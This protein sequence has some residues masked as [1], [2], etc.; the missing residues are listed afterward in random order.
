LLFATTVFLA[1]ALLFIVEPMFARMTLPRL[2]GAPAVWNTAMVFYQAVLLAGYGA[3]HLMATRLAPQRQ[4]LLPVVLMASAVLLL[5]PGIAAGWTPPVEQNPIPWLL[6]VMTATVGLPFL[7]LSTLSPLLQRWFATCGAKNP[8][9]LY[10]ASNAGSLIGLLA[11]PLVI[12]PWLGLQQQSWWWS[13]G[14]VTV[15]A[16][17]A[18][19]AAAVW[20][21]RGASAKRHE[22]APAALDTSAAATTSQRLRWV[23]LALAPSSLMLGV[24]SHLTTEV[25][26]MPLLW[27]V[28]LA[29]YL[30][31]FI[32]VFAQ[33]QWIKPSWMTAALPWVVLPLTVL[34]GMR[35]G[36]KLALS[37]GWNL[38]ALFVGAMV[39]HGRLAA[40]RP[41]AGRLT[42]F[43]WRLSVGGMLGGVFNALLAPVLFRWVMEYP[44]SVALVCLLAS[45]IERPRWTDAAGPVALGAGGWLLGEWVRSWPAELAQQAALFKLAAPAAGALLLRKRPLAFGLAVGAL[46]AAATWLPGERGRVLAVERSFFGVHRVRTSLGDAFHRLEHGTTTHGIQSFEPEQRGEPL[47][48]YSRIGPVGQLFAA[49]RR[50]ERPMPKVG[51]VGLGAGAVAAYARPG[52]EWTFFEIDPVVERIARDPRLFTHLADSRGTVKVTLGDARLSLQQTTEQFDV[53]LLDAYSSD[54]IPLHL[55]TRE[56]IQHYL[57]RLKRDGWLIF[58][59]SNRHLEL[60]PVIAA[61]ARDAGL[62]H[63]IQEQD[64]ISPENRARGVFTSSWAVMCRNDAYLGVL[65]TDLRWRQPQN[66]RHLPV[67]TDDYASILPVW[68]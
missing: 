53:L 51:A 43:Y 66:K 25:A 33:R 47:G 7:A 17:V 48:Y 36:N 28:P 13:A 26:A 40:E 52:E 18:A 44:I 59:F 57:A 30:V 2:G 9:W 61:L 46:F 27:V 63:R 24:T 55:L 8:Y 64:T 38:L 50:M 41:P 15:A 60:E 14:Y 35:V 58:H 16:L 20:R 68:K 12:E 32:L 62:A 1:A 23:L 34:Y 56:A 10:A 42:E 39:C 29:I 31:T 19:C 65:L 11:Y 67:W 49:W 6:L 22:D 5:P 37:G 21:C 4:T 3:A 54:A 45:P